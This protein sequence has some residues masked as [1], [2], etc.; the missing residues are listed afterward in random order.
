MMAQNKTF[1][2]FA[3]KNI[4]E[5]NGDKTKV[6]KNQHLHSYNDNYQLQLAI[7]YTDPHHKDKSK[8]SL[9]YF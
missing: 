8:S 1:F 9:S 6:L 4:Q 5:R 2:A 7:N 3:Y